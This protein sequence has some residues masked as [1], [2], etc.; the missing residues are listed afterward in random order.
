MI[1]TA[2]RLAPKAFVCVIGNKADLKDN[3]QVE[4]EE[5]HSMCV[6]MGTHI[7]YFHLSANETKVVEHCFWD[8][9]SRPLI[10]KHVVSDMCAVWL[11]ICLISSSYCSELQHKLRQNN[12]YNQ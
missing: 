9:I 3:T 8:I 11:S 2:T 4:C 5:A 7:V 1:N 10:Y 12:F 6:S